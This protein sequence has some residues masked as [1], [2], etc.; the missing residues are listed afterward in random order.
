MSALQVSSLGIEVPRGSPA[1]MV[2]YAP[3]EHFL[4]HSVNLLSVRFT[5]TGN[6]T[7]PVCAVPS[8][9]NAVRLEQTSKVNVE[10]VLRWTQLTYLRLY[11][12]ELKT[13]DVSPL[14]QL[15]TLRLDR[16]QLKTIDVSPLTQLRFLRLDGNRFNTSVPT[17]VRNNIHLRCL[18]LRNN[19]FFGGMDWLQDMPDLRWLDVRH[20]TLQGHMPALHSRA[21]LEFLGLG[22]SGLV[23]NESYILSRWPRLENH[24]DHFRSK[25]VDFDAEGEPRYCIES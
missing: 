24:G 9:V 13:I 14:T 10:C 1:R 21:P 12:N 8:S 6:E 3:I 16:N 11:H 15:R 17:A 2:P 25:D 4:K 5:G 19:A 23:Y 22:S 18:N 7:F 20:N